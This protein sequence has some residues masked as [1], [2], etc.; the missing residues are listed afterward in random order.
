MLARRF[1]PFVRRYRV[2]EYVSLTVRATEVGTWGTIAASGRR[3]GLLIK[4][5]ISR[6]GLTEVRSFDRMVVAGYTHAKEVLAG[7]DRA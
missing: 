6:F 7:P 5:P 2:P 4:P 1:L 3:A